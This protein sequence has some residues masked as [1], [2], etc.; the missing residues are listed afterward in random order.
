M[1]FSITIGSGN[2][3][4][5]LLGIKYSACVYQAANI[6]KLP[7]RLLLMSAVISLIA[8]LI[9]AAAAAG[10]ISVSALR[11]AAAF[12]HFLNGVIG[13]IYL[14]HLFGGY[15][16]KGT[17]GV[18]IGVILFNEGAVSLLY[19][20]IGSGGRNAEYLIRVIHFCFSSFQ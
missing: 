15:I 12:A 20:V 2:A 5:Q 16:G 17:A 11:C 4:K 19:F 7:S 14:R 6:G 8:A 18:V 13:G 3:I 9:T 1:P 10:T